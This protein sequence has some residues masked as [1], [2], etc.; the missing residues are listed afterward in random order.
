MAEEKQ[1]TCPHCARPCVFKRDS[2]GRWLGTAVGG[3][4]GYFLA[5]TL[6]LV[7]TF[8]GFPVAVAAAT[9][10]LVI[11]ATAGNGLGKVFDDTAAICPHCKKSMVL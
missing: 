8:L 9:V 11:G 7:G 5:S 4:A 1:V 6:G 10:G 3:G 2:T